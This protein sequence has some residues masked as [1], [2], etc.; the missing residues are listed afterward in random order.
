LGSGEVGHGLIEITDVCSP[1]KA[2]DT[3]PQQDN[4]KI[5]RRDAFLKLG[6]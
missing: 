3:N 6:Y 1:R 2:L 5:Q 4:L